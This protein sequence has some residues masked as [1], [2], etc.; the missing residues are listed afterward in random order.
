MIHKVNSIHNFLANETAQFC[1]SEALDTIKP[2]VVLKTR[3]YNKVSMSIYCNMQRLEDV[4]E[5]PKCAGCC[6]TG[7]LALWL[8]DSGV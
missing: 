4:K 5:L 8:E 1:V 2:A 3:S 7:H 6:R